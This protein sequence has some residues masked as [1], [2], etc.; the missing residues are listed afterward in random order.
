MDALR[1]AR[2][3]L[4]NLFG[5]AASEEADEDSTVAVQDQS[6]VQIGHISGGTQHFIGSASVVNLVTPSR[7]LSDLSALELEAAYQIVAEWKKQARQK[8][9]PSSDPQGARGEAPAAGYY[10][11]V[12]QNFHGQVGQVAGRDIINKG[13]EK[14]EPELP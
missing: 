6:R 3:E 10:E 5:I 11:G 9:D 2:E 12:Q 1:K 7:K 4:E 13:G 8:G 14:N